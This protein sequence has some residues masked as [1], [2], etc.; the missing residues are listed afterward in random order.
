MINLLPPKEKEEILQENN[1]SLVIVLGNIFVICLVCLALILFSLKFYILA[2]VSSEEFFL[3]DAEKQYKTPDFLQTKQIVQKYNET[4]IKIDNF[5]KKE[6]HLYDTLK[7]ILEIQRPNGLLFTRITIDRKKEDNA[8]KVSL[9]GVSDT[10]DNLL[11]FKDNI[12]NN[13][14][15]GNLNFPASNWVRSKDISFSLSFETK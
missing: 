12:E 8:F 3:N 11:I 2:R 10:R 1:M 5:Y 15:I 7:T 14:V 6:V 4:L 9:N 13:K